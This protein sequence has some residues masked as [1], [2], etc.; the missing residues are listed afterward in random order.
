MTWS[1]CGWVG[2]RIYADK[3]EEVCDSSLHSNVLYHHLIVRRYVCLFGACAT[4][5]TEW[6]SGGIAAA[7][8][9]PFLQKATAL[10]LLLLLL[11]FVIE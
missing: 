10:L 3:R 2:V 11:C 4:L 5:L 6:A 8:F 7:T 1:V 9:H